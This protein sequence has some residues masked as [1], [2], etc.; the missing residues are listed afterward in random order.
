MMNEQTTT[1]AFTSGI[2]GGLVVRSVS[3]ATAV[4]LAILLVAALF[5]TPIPA[6]AAADRATMSTDGALVK[7][8]AHVSQDIHIMTR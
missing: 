6:T 3:L 7:P 5:S 1:L 2:L 4:G 8:V